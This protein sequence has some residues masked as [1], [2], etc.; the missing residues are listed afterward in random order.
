MPDDYEKVNSCLRESIKVDPDY[1]ELYYHLAHI[2]FVAW[3][4]GYKTDRAVTLEAI[5]YAD[6]CIA[7]EPENPRGYFGKGLLSFVLKDWQTMQHY[8]GKAV[9]LAP[10]NVEILSNAGI[11]LI[12][13]GECSLEEYRD[14]EGKMS[15]YTQGDCQWKPGWDMLQKAFTIDKGNLYPVKNY[16]IAHVYNLWGE[17][18]KS[19]NQ[20]QLAVSPGFIWYEMH[21]AIAAAGMK[22]EKLARKHFDAVQKIIGSNKLSDAHEHFK[23]WHI[24][25]YWDM[26]QGFLIEYGFQ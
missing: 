7:L 13:G 18:E 10:N 17:Y 16:G 24:P 15:S 8:L 26:S 2:S 6:K 20:M 1:A 21:S 23:R 9:A 5:E 25:Q 4:M 12:T 22:D 19:Y 3:Q 11:I 14:R